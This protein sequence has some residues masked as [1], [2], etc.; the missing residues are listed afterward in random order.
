MISTATGAVRRAAAASLAA[1][2][3]LAPAASLAQDYENQIAARQGQ[4]KIMAVNLGVL[5][6]MAR[7]NMDYDAGLAET[8]AENLVTISRI[9]QSFHWPEG[10]DNMA[11]D[12]TR[13]QPT[14]WDDFD[15]F[16]AKWGDFGTAAEALVEVAGDG[17][18]ALGPAVGELGGTCKACHEAHRGP[19]LE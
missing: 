11:L 12:T 14:I 3:V 13:A 6:G 16:A 9:D 1:V 2:L 18:E 10:S 15:D 7:G 8:A 5:G 19:E 4:F 17:R